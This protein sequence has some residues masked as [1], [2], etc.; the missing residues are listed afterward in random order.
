MTI[1]EFWQQDRM[2]LSLEITAIFLSCLVVVAGTRYLA[3]RGALV[4]RLKNA[5]QS[6]A[7]RNVFIVIRILCAIAA[8]LTLVVTVLPG[9]TPFTPDPNLELGGIVLF[10][11]WPF[12]A[13]QLFFGCIPM[14]KHLTAQSIVPW[15]WLTCGVLVGF[16]I[17]SLAIG[18]IF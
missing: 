18:L 16:W 9:I 4:R 2:T 8:A 13:L 5:G 1:T 6:T 12:I 3:D 14:E 17:D 7:G 10:F 15:M 11:L